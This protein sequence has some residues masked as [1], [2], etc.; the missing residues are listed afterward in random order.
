M[1]QELFNL[2][3]KTA[4]V[5]GASSG[6]GR[7]IAIAYAKSGAKVIALG[8]SQQRLDELTKES[9]QFLLKNIDITDKKAVKILME[10]IESQNIKIDILVNSA[11]IG[12]LSPVFEDENNQILEKTYEINVQAL[13]NMTSI[14]A[15]H[16]K[17]HKIAG[18]IINIASINGENCLRP[19]LAIY[20]SSKAAVIQMTKALV[21]ELSPYNIR[22]N[23]ISPG[24]FHTPLTDYKLSNAELKA[25]QAKIIPL[26]FVPDPMEI[27]GSALFLASN[28]ASKYVTGSCVT[29][30]GGNSWGG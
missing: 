4:L 26:G 2:T 5:T 16:M 30:D 25:Q 9:D 14:I 6:L 23:T 1:F 27:A 29:I 15:K 21:G 28:N 3:G 11:G 7:A 8:R 12:K 17:N 20:A 18:S 19:E 10:D 13:W 24:L 22:I